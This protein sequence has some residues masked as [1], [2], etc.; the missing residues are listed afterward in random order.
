MPDVYECKIIDVSQLNDAVFSITVVSGELAAQSA[1]GQ[2]LHIK[3]G[4]ERLLRRPISICTVRGEKVRFVFEVKGEGTLW[5]SKCLPG[6]SLNILGALG[7]GFAL[8]KGKVIVTGGGIGVPPMLFAAES[9]YDTCTAILGFR[10]KQNVI[11]AEE[12]NKACDEVFITTDD[13]SMGVCGMVTVPLEPLLEK[14]GFDAVLSCGPVLMQRAVAG[15]CAKYSVQ[16]QV[17]LEER[18]GCGVGACLVCAC[19]TTQDGVEQ[20]SSVCVDGPVFDAAIV[21]W[22]MES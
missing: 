4:A 16:C 2:F 15:L 18:M 13:G 12:F 7:N 19:A 10:S 5:L 21:K 9:A 17:S 14:G 22:K 8:P 11:L 6:T 3:C 20:M 1:P